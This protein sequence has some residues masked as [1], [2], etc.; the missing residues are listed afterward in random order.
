MNKK[1]LILV[2]TVSILVMAICL[3]GCKK[4]IGSGKSTEYDID[5]DDIGEEPKSEVAETVISVDTSKIKKLNNESDELSN[6]R[7]VL[8]TIDYL[9]NLANSNLMAMDYYASIAFGKSTVLIAGNEDSYAYSREYI[10]KDKKEWFF[11]NFTID[12]DASAVVK[13]IMESAEERYTNDGGET[14]YK[15]HGGSSALEEDCLDRFLTSNSPIIYENMAKSGKNHAPKIYTREEYNEF[16]H[17]RVSYDEIDNALITA[18]TLVDG[19]V[20]YD[21]DEGLY[22][23]EFDVN[24]SNDSEALE[25]GR[26]NLSAAGGSSVSYEKQHQ[27][28]TIWEEGLFCYYHTEN[29]WTAK[30]VG[31]K[32]GSANNYQKWFTYNKDNVEKLVIPSDVSWIE[33]CKAGE[34]D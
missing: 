1:F 17:V 22:T 6:D 20:T 32:Y 10:V 4:E 19:K 12:P 8:E 11:Q 33:N 14:I 34:K 27:T 29:L 16:K 18:D 23:I 13:N 15:R 9:Y 2:A 3:V 21:E 30:F 28:I 24:I 5:F 31:V 26:K 25:N 7:D